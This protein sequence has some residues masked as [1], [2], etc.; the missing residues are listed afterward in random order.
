MD[1]ATRCVTN[2]DLVG[3]YKAF[4]EP[5]LSGYNWGFF[6][7]YLY[8]LGEVARP[9]GS[10]MPLILDSRVQFTLNAYEE[11]FEGEPRWPQG[12]AKRYEHYCQ[13]LEAW[14]HFLGLMRADQIELFLFDHP[15]SQGAPELLIV[16]AAALRLL[17][18]DSADRYE[19]YA[20]L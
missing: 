15:P 9:E 17:D 4:S 6:T 14:T 5:H 12:A 2:G 8:F 1:P 3:A 18:S 16:A 10:P 11:S 7:K 20:T 13:M 19:L